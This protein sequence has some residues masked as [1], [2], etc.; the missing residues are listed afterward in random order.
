M[1]VGWRIS[2]PTVTSL[3]WW[4]LSALFVILVSLW[5]NAAHYT[6][7]RR[8]E[9]WVLWPVTVRMFAPSYLSANNDEQIRFTVENMDSKAVDVAF[10]LINSGTLWD[11][12]KQAENNNV[13]SGPIQSQEQ[14]YRAV[15]L[16]LPASISQVYR[17]RG[18]D[19]GLN[20]SGGLVS[21]TPR[22]IPIPVQ[23]A[24]ILQ[25]KQLADY[26]GIALFGLVIW[27]VRGLWDKIGERAR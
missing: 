9:E 6:F 13:Y 11:F 23:V 24:P 19:A 20:I 21:A 3:R 27:L 7:K 15:D 25:A 4:C 16:Y 12:P 22:T 1:V 14:I 8:S 2:R 10:R 18:K 26:C 5:F 17:M